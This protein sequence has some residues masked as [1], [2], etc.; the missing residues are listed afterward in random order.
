[1]PPPP[2]QCLVASLFL[3]QIV[4]VLFIGLPHRPPCPNLTPCLIHPEGTSLILASGAVT[5]HHTAWR[6]G[7]PSLCIPHNTGTREDYHANF[8]L[9]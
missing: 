7:H 9:T 3:T 5:L 8:L 4:V 1:M 6:D 2:S